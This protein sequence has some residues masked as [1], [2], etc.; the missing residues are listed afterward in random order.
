MLRLPQQRL[1]KP[2]PKSLLA[3]LL[4]LLLR[5][6]LTLLSPRQRLLPKQAR[7]P[8]RCLPAQNLQKWVTLARSAAA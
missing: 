2:L 5:L 1:P 8:W 6:L 7:A 4:S 3:V